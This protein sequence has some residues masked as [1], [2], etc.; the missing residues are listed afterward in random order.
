M[1]GPF[2]TVKTVEDY[3]RAAVDATPA[4]RPTHL[5]AAEGLAVDCFSTRAFLREL[6]ANDVG[7]ETLR[8]RIA[9][10]L[11]AMAA[12]ERDISGIRDA[13]DFQRSQLNNESAAFAILDDSIDL[14]ATPIDEFGLA[15]FGLGGPKAAHGYVFVLLA[16]DFARLSNGRDGVLRALTVGRDVHLN[17]DDPDDLADI[18]NGWIEL[19]DRDEGGALLARSATRRAAAKPF[20][21]PDPPDF[22]QPHPPGD[23]FPSLRSTFGPQPSASALLDLIRS[24][25]SAPSLETIA[26]A[27]YG[28]DYQDHLAALTAIVDTGLVSTPT[29]WV[30]AEV[31][32]LYRWHM[33]GNTDHL[34]RALCCAVLSLDASLLYPTAFMETTGPY[35]VESC[36]VLGGEYV[37]AAQQLLAWRYSATAEAD[38]DGQVD[39]QSSVL[40]A[41]LLAVLSGAGVPDWSGPER[42]FT[43][44]N[45]SLARQRASGQTSA[46]VWRHLLSL[47][48]PGIPDDRSGYSVIATAFDA[49]EQPP[50]G[51]RG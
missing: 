37:G 18:A 32:A 15:E 22:P 47:A 35:L 12:A 21:V 3:V 40:A 4:E 30:P 45:E 7:D 51:N 48:V 33:G 28:M 39:R 1:T 10:Q 17:S 9:G 24:N 16:Q 2:P 27:D 14:F 20:P 49:V 46:T 44:L 31:L 43:A 19:I 26:A 5:L 38:S 42:D 41:L 23:P 50:S 11:L 13:A 25:I 29:A 36:L 34:A 6:I 8:R